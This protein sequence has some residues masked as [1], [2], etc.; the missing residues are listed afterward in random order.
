MS[1]RD[2]E[3]PLSTLFSTAL[4]LLR[5][6]ALDEIGHACGHNLIATAGL[7]AV[8]GVAEAIKCGDIQGRVV[9]MGTPAEEGGGGKIKMI[10]AGAYDDV[11]C[12]LMVHPM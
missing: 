10:R 7:S 11:F 8:L 9:A 5:Y 3:A 6:D 2:S 1:V 12:C 4:T